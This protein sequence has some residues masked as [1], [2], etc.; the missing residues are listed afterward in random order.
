MRRAPGS[1]SRFRFSAAP[2]DTPQTK[3]N[4][5]PRPFFRSHPLAAKGEDDYQKLKAAKE[6]E[7]LMIRGV[8]VTDE[9]QDVI[10]FIINSFVRPITTELYAI[11]HWH[12]TVSV[13]P[14]H[15]QFLVDGKTGVRPVTTMPA[16][17]AVYSRIKK[18]HPNVYQSIETG[19][20][21]QQSFKSSFGPCL[22]EQTFIPIRLLDCLTKYISYD[23]RRYASDLS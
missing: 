1:R 3:Q 11:K 20:Q 22:R 14:S 21:H 12:V 7:G 17:V 16:A 19:R 18:R 23:I 9:L 15:L 2:R 10:Q 5:N 13:N 4:D 6:M 8:T